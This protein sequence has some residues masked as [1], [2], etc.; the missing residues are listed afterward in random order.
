MVKNHSFKEN[1]DAEMRRRGDQKGL[2]T[3]VVHA[4]NDEDSLLGKYVIS[5]LFF[6]VVYLFRGLAN[7]LNLPPEEYDRKVKTQ[8]NRR[9][10]IQVVEHVV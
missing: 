1:T 6:N 3:L 9:G 7:A 2:E 4:V 8:R 5:T 10:L